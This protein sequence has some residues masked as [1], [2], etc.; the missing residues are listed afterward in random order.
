MWLCISALAVYP[1]SDLLSRTR[2]NRHGFLVASK[3]KT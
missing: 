3:S 2:S 1:G